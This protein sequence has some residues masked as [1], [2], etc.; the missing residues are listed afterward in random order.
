MN[1]VAAQLPMDT[2]RQAKF[3][4][5]M[6]W[7]ICEI[8]EATGEK[9]KTLHSWKARDEWDRADNVERIGGALEARLVL[10]IMKDGKTGAITKR[11]TFCTASW[12][13]KR[14]SSDIRMAE[15]RPD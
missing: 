5:W 12:S 6:G 1:S 4:Y 15:P 10:L 9:E 13:G 3:L 8:A 14:E 7:R 11:S 2:R